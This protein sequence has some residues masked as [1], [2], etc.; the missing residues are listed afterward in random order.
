MVQF[1]ALFLTLSFNLPLAKSL[2][3]CY[4]ILGNNL[5]DLYTPCNVQTPFSMC[6]RSGGEGFGGN[7]DSKCFANG[8]SQNISPDEV[9]CILGM[10]AV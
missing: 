8:I 6:W 4:D 9:S 2:P 10:A 3:A 1:V 7:T 5:P